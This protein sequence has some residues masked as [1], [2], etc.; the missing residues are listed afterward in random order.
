MSETQNL[1]LRMS[2]PDDLQGGVYANV[3][4]VWHGPFDFTLDF[5][6]AGMAQRDEHGE[7]FV[8][9]PVVARVKVPPQVIF[10]I[11]Q[12][13]AENVDRYERTFGPITQ[14]RTGET[15]PDT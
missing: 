9:A 2:V 1:P 12:A 3:V 15:G 4:A 5:G 10:R 8:P 7:N 6:V 11:A 14:P 13:I